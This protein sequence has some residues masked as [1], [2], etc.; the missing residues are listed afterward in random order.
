MI[1]SA[2]P[3]E[4]ES[5][6]IENPAGIDKD[7]L[8]GKYQEVEDYKLDKAKKRDKFM[9]QAARKALDLPAIETDEDMKVASD[10]TTHNHF[11]GSQGAS[12]P[13]TP[14]AP[15]PAPAPSTTPP[16]AKQPGWGRKA[17]AGALI[18][19]ALGGPIAGYYA[20]NYFGGEDTDTKL[21]TVILD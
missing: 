13:Q 17:A 3:K 10:N 12:N 2:N 20:A 5:L 21:R 15:S 4:P 19:A 16:T 14:Q 6:P 1:E 7:F 8:Y 11:Y 9:D 18:A